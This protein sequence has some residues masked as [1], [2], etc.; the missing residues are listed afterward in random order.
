VRT[1]QPEADRRSVTLSADGGDRAIVLDID[2][3]RIREVLMNL[4]V[5]ALRHTTNGQSISVT[6]DAARPDV[7]I[8]VVDTGA[9]IPPEEFGRIFDRFYKGSQSRGSGLGLAIAKS[10]IHAHGGD[11]SA[12]SSPGKGTTVTFTLPITA[13]PSV[14]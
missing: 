10:I 4:L 11:I 13:D 1:L 2:P 6:V 3:V 7:G 8:A 9:G 12:T 5:N 14:K